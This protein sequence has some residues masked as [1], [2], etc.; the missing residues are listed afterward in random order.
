ME[1][2]VSS[3]R[4]WHVANRIKRSSKSVRDK[5]LD[6]LLETVGQVVTTEELA[7]VSNEKKE[8]AKRVREL[9]TEDGF[10]IATKAT[11]RPDLGV[12]EY[13]LLSANRMAEVHDRHIQIDLQRAVFQRDNNA[14]RMCGWTVDRYS[15]QDSRILELHNLQP[16]ALQITAQTLIVLCS[17]CHDRVHAGTLDIS[18]IGNG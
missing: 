1:P 11:G 14:C 5:I 18:H 9:R 4:R 13:M 2:D 17:P 3:A 10:A 7:Y 16:N 6:F 8:F 15:L 12:G